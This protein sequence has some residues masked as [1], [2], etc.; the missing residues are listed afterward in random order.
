MV[1]VAAGKPARA[2]LPDFAAIK[3]FI[4]MGVLLEGVHAA[5]GALAQRLV[6][7]RLELLEPMVAGVAL[8]VVGWHGAGFRSQVSNLKSKI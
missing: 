2:D 1:R 4:R 3:A 5:G 6:L 8:V 7:H